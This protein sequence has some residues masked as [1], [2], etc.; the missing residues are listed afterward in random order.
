[1]SATPIAGST[2][3]RTSPAGTFTTAIIRPVS[4]RTFTRMLK[5]RPK[6][7]LV[8]PRVHQAT[9][10]AGAA[11][12]LMTGLLIS[13]GGRDGGGRGQGAEHGRG[14]GDPAEDPALRADHLQ[15][16]AL[17]LGEVGPDAVGDDQAV[18]AAVVRLADGGVHAHLGGRSEER[19]VGKECRSRWSACQYKIKM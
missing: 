7:A 8:S 13:D 4:V 9:A 16:D 19:R 3:P 18:E 11:V 5:A 1:M 15:A 10:R 17:E 6:K 14:I 12:V 2:V